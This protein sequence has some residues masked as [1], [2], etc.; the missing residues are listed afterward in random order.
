MMNNERSLLLA[1]TIEAKMKERGL[2][3]IEFSELMKTQP[4]TVTKWL[5]GSHNF[6]I[7]TLFEIEKVLQFSIFN[8]NT[9]QP[10]HEWPWHIKKNRTNQQPL[11]K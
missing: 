6:T 7:E 1:Q 4:S 2:S 3:R 9:T 8:F 10:W 5:K 11:N